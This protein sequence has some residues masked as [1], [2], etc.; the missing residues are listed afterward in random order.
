MALLSRKEFAALC[1]TSTAIVTTNINRGKL[2]EFEKKLDTENPLNNSFF[3]RYI[4]KS[5]EKKTKLPTKD[6][7]DKLYNE[8]VEK[9]KEKVEKEVFSGAEKSRHKRNNKKYEDLNDWDSRKKKADA[10]K[11]ELAV[12]KAQLEINKLSGKLIPLELTDN[13]LAAYTRSIIT[14]FE[15]DMLNLASIYTDILASGDRK[16]LAEI[17]DK[18]NEKLDD[19]VNRA[20]EVAKQEIENA[21]ENYKEVRNRGEKK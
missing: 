8:T 17:T 11:A 20:L 1:H 21:V 4:N 12:E 14:V 15:N 16:Y 9:V 18:L 19:S 5:N 6:E 3:N 7:I 10:L 2:V 13:I